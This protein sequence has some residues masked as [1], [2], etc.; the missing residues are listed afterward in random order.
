MGHVTS[1][2]SVAVSDAS[3]SRSGRARTMWRLVIV[4]VC[5]LCLAVS[6]SAQRSSGQVRSARSG[7]PLA[8]CQID[9]LGP[10]GNLVFRVYTDQGGTFV[11]DGARGTYTVWVLQ[12]GRSQQ[13]RVTADNGTLEPSV[14]EVPW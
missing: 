3:Q 5:T 7:A 1:D 4:C 13:F 6:V 11:V 2:V 9:F 10:N 12:G 8:G 14:L